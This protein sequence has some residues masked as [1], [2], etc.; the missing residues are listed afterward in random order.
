MAATQRLGTEVMLADV[1][2]VS[3]TLGGSTD[4]GP[5]HHERLLSTHAPRV[6]GPVT[7]WGTSGNGT[8]SASSVVTL[9]GHSHGS[10]IQSPVGPPTMGTES[11]DA[12]LGTGSTHLLPLSR[13]PLPQTSKEA[14]KK[15][16]N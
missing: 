6:W 12:P 4:T 11:P 3:C 9:C 14:K 16:G 2:S 7:C 1:A 15:E 13:T 5:F 10:G 8:C